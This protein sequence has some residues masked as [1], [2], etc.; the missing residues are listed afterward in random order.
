MRQFH[1]RANMPQRSELKREGRKSTHPPRKAPIGLLGG[2]GVESARRRADVLKGRIVRA[3]RV[4][5]SRTLEAGSM[6]YVWIWVDCGRMLVVSLSRTCRGEFGIL[7]GRGCSSLDGVR[8]ACGDVADEVNW[9]FDWSR[10]GSC[11]SSGWLNPG[12]SLPRCRGDDINS[13]PYC[14]IF[15]VWYAPSLMSS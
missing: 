15:S 4:P 10:W 7:R 14:S 1:A 2:R 6:V 3:V 12:C 11:W 9:G 13:S 5:E 8:E